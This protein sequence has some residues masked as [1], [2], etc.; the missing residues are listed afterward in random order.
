MSEHWS[1]PD[2]FCRGILQHRV[3]IVASIA[4]ITL[5]AL[6]AL[7]QVKL[8][9]SL[10]QSYMADFGEF[11]IYQER[12]QLLGGDSDDILYIATREGEALFTAEKLN[13]IRAAAQELEALPEVLRVVSLPDLPR[14]NPN[15]GL[16]LREQFRIGAARTLLLKGKAP[17]IEDQ[18]EIE[19]YWPDDPDE[20]AEVD[21]AA[22]KEEMKSDAQVAS[23]ALSR[24]ATAHAMVVR[25]HNGQELSPGEQRLLRHRIDE[26][27]E[28]H[29]LGLR[30]PGSAEPGV[31]MAGIIISQ[32]WMLSEMRF[33]IL[34]LFPIGAIIIC[35]IVYA[36][37]H[38][39]SVV[40]MTMLIAVISI[41]WALAAT[42]I[43]FGELS[44]LVG[45]TPLLILVLSTSDT[46]HLSSAY[47]TELGRGLNREE[48]LLKTMRDVGGACILN[49]IT[50]FDGFLSLMLIPV[51]T[52]RHLALSSAVG[53]ASALLLAMILI[54]I[55]FSYLPAV[56]LPSK[57]EGLGFI[58]A[59]ADWLL[60]W[61]RHLC[62][63]H[64]YLMLGANLLLVG[65]S[66]YAMWGMH[67]DPDFVQRFPRGHALR[68][69][70]EF[71]DKEMSGTTVIEVFLTTD[72]QRLLEPQTLLAIAEFEQRVKDVP[73]VRSARSVNTIFQLVDSTVDYGTDTG[74]PATRETAAA[75]LTM[76]AQLDESLVRS[77]IA[78]ERGITRLL[79]QAQPTAFMEILKLSEQIERLGQTVFPKE[80]QVE[81][82]GY[83]PIIGRSVRQ[84]VNNQ[85]QGFALCFVT[86]ALIMT[87]GL[88]SIKLGL[89]A[90][91]ANVVPLIFLGGW[92]GATLEI[93]DSDI[94]AIAVLS[95]SLAVDDTIHFFHRFQIEL[96][97]TG[98]KLKALDATYQYTG[99][100]TVQTTFILGAGLAPFALSGLMTVNMLG[101]YLVL[102]LVAAMVAE[103]LI[104]P[105][106]LRIFPIAVPHAETGERKARSHRRRQQNA[107]VKT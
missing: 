77:M 75:S 66:I 106:L 54:P 100:A 30:D 68:Q 53:V 48:A 43:V 95:F 73:G 56:P 50:I 39:V 38:R 102:T 34:A 37:F 96:A 35:A 78:E 82:S 27:L 23:I 9:N 90:L 14:L 55:A 64:P 67:F 22:L 92:L 93:V 47:Y 84:I 5:G 1:L 85:L 31:Y 104:T 58:N 103:L 72:P 4:L 49:S 44:V 17:P 99:R 51:T 29:R 3:K 79:V 45:A 28:K 61:S 76:A 6:L 7:T 62:M 70:V 59:L 91:P 97:A 42:A 21:L 10:V 18:I 107:A 71:F 65:A 60:G 41:I 16:G 83:F 80:V 69:S 63:K 19:H 57:K 12:A 74:L 52:T 89:L 98:D 36:F 105:A 8:S 2:W 88:R 86:V 46:I 101:T 24:D 94:I 15:R 25:L 81:T 40:V 26:I 11:K 13:A 87:W 20:Q 32:G 33:A